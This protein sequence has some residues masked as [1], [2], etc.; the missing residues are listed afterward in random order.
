MSFTRSSRHSCSRSPAPYKRATMI[1][2]LPSSCFMTRAT[3]SAQDDRYANRHASARNVVDGADLDAHYF[4]IQEQ[5]RAERLIL[6]RCADAT[7]RREP[8]EKA[9]NLGRAHVRRMPLPMKDD[10]SPN[11]VDVRALGSATV[12]FRTDRPTN[13]VEQLRRTTRID[14][15]RRQL[16]AHP[17]ISARI[18]RHASSRRRWHRRRK[19]SNGT[20]RFEC[21]PKSSA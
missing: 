15:R 1:H 16:A 18:V 14:G 2:S 3:S 5:E 7:L 12:M 21:E 11:P 4:A 17:L 9:G 10:V 6:R 20:H 13:T 8:G 19:R